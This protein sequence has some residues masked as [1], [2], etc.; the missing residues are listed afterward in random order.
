M[1]NS[2]SLNSKPQRISV[3]A[4]LFPANKVS[5]AGT[6]SH[7]IL[8]LATYWRVGCSALDEVLNYFINHPTNAGEPT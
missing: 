6:S 7:N 3:A 8:L 4:V 1:V 2:R 5:Y